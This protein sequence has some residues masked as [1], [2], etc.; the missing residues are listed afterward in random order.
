MSDDINTSY[1]IA[2]CSLNAQSVGELDSKDGKWHLRQVVAPGTK[3]VVPDLVTY[4]MICHGYN[5]EGHLVTIARKLGYHLREQNLSEE[6]RE[7]VYDKLDDLVADQ[8]NLTE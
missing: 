1:V 6:Q 8:T 5:D 3:H 2:V 7:Q 4:F